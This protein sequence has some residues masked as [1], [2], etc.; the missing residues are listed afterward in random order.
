MLHRFF[1]RDILASFNLSSPIAK[2]TKANLEAVLP[3]G[4]WLRFHF[5]DDNPVMYNV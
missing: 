3:Q 4:V 2:N 5:D 1:N